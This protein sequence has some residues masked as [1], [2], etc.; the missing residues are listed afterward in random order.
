MKWGAYNNLLSHVDADMKI[1]MKC[2]IVELQLLSS[3]SNNTKEDD[4]IF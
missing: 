2:K 3:N 1:Y 4:F